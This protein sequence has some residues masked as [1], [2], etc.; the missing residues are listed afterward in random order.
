MKVKKIG[1]DK[2]EVDTGY[3]FGGTSFPKVCIVH[4]DEKLYREILEDEFC[5]TDEVIDRE[6]FIERFFEFLL[7]WF[8][9]EFYGREFDLTLL[10]NHYGE[11][12]N[13]LSIFKEFIWYI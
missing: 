13:E 7:L 10:A 4:F 6:K 11:D 1:D 2:Y 8:P 9:S 3:N 12:S 5:K